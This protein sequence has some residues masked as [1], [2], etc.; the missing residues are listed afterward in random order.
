MSKNTIY[1]VI[2]VVCFIITG[3]LAYTFIFS[4]KG[5]QISDDEM[6]WVKCNNSTCGDCYE[7]GLKEY[8]DE[9]QERANANPMAIVTPAITCRKC[10]KNS[11]YQAEK[12]QNPE[13]GEVFIRGIVP[14]ALEDTCP[15]CG[16]S[17]IAE[18]RKARLAERGQAN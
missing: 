13:C 10:G 16:Y 7:M 9:V 17:S 3:I 5:S 8:H 12:C 11:V 1:I 18:S 2:I 15:K 4:S 14:Q 6:T